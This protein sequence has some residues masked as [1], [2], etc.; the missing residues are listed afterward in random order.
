MLWHV[1]SSTPAHYPF[2]RFRISPSFFLHALPSPSSRFGP[3]PHRFMH[4]VA[5]LYTDSYCNVTSE[6]YFS[7]FVPD[8]WSR[9]PGSF[10]VISR[11]SQV[12]PPLSLTLPLLNCH[13][14]LRVFPCPV[15]TP[16]GT[17]FFLLF[18]TRL[19]SFSRTFSST[20]RHCQDLQRRSQM[21]PPHPNPPFE[22]LCWEGCMSSVILAIR[23]N[24]MS[25]FRFVFAFLVHYCT[26]SFY[27]SPSGFMMPLMALVGILSFV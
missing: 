20:R 27:A 6:Y 22:C 23:S 4:F 25:H 21:I 7:F 5:G 3:F 8:W 13:R 19:N 26:S 16:N 1:P 15:C 24:F 17:V 12:P 11:S 18:Q 9:I 14:C 10:T 2:L